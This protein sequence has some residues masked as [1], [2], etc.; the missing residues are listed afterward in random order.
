MRSCAPDW[1]HSD[2][3]ANVA[4]RP[5]AGLSSIPQGGPT[6]SK[7]RCPCAGKSRLQSGRQGPPAPATGKDDGATEEE[8]AAM[9]DRLD[10]LLVVSPGFKIEEGQ[11]DDAEEK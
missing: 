11:F 7:A 3:P 6:R 1:Q 9:L 4:L 10:N 5:A 8:R 2:F